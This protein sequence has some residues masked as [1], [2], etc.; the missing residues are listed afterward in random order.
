MRSEITVR[1]ESDKVSFSSL[2]DENTVYESRAHDLANVINYDK[3]T[4]QDVNIETI[5]RACELAGLIE[6]KG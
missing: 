2:L 1:T 5:I 4:Y 6:I 3:E